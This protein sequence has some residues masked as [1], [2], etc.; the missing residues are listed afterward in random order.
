M[1]YILQAL[2]DYNKCRDKVNYLLLLNYIKIRLKNLTAPFIFLTFV[3]FYVV[4][5]KFDTTTILTVG[6]MAKILLWTILVSLAYVIV[7][8]LALEWLHR[9]LEK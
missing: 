5:A 3:I 4:F 8:I 1:K 9:K 7:C 6:V 2:E